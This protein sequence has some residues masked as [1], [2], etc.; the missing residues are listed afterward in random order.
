MRVIIYLLA[1]TNEYISFGTCTQ[2]AFAAGAAKYL[3]SASLPQRAVLLIALLREGLRA[4][5]LIAVLLEGLRAVLLI[6][7]LL[8][9]L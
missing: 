8:E 9:G 7:V 2:P 3:L 5:L 1:A 6:A 4:V